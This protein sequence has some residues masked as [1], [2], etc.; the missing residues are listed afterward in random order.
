MK[1]YEGYDR[2]RDV[3][4]KVMA[5]SES[6][7]SRECGFLEGDDIRGMCNLFGRSLVFGAQEK[8][9]ER[10]SDCRIYET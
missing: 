1:R 3:T 2:Y 6:H 7:C 10:C 4:V 9:F 8:L 5:S